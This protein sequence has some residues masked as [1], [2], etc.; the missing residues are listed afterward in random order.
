VLGLN[1]RDDDSL[2]S[3]LLGAWKLGPQKLLGSNQKWCPCETPAGLLPMSLTW[4]CLWLVRS[5]LLLLYSE[6]TNKK[7]YI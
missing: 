5:G 4:G 2:V 6:K 1:T 7:L 3:L